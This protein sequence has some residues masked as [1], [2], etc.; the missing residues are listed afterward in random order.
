MLGVVS[1][2]VWVGCVGDVKGKKKG[3]CVAGYVEVG[4]S[5]R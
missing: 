3:S 2:W 4:N 1:G 5:E